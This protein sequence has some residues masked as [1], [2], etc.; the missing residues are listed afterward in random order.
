MSFQ[1]LGFGINSL[2]LHDSLNVSQD[3]HDDPMEIDEIH[4]NLDDQEVVDPSNNSSSSESLDISEDI[5]NDDSQAHSLL[6]ALSPTNLGAQ[7]ALKKQKLLMPPPPSASSPSSSPSKDSDL[8]DYEFDTSSMHPYRQLPFA[9]KDPDR[10]SFNPNVNSSFFSDVSDTPNTRN[11]AHSSF[12]YNTMMNRSYNY[13]KQMFPEQY[14]GANTSISVHEPDSRSSAVQVH[15]HHYYSSGYED[16]GS[17]LPGSAN[18]LK[19]YRSQIMPHGDTFDEKVTQVQ[20]QAYQGML[21]LPWD[22]KSSPAERVPYVLSSYLQLALNMVLS[23]YLLHIIVSIVQTI[24]QDVAHRLESQANNLLVEIASCERSYHENNCSPDTIVPALEKMCAYWEKCMNQ[25]PFKGGNTSSV[26]AQI[27]GMILN[28]LVEP[29]SFKVFLVA[30]GA[31]TV[32]FSC[33]FAFGYIRA[34]TYYGWAS[35]QTAGST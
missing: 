5:E 21:P 15:H 14:Q 9:S 34:K 35:A 6:N 8:H 25:D 1:E 12:Y 27:I 7:Y 33:N 20:R 23:C 10:S 22:S 31:I 32:V 11:D 4:F 13:R 16:S 24:R 19:Q 2:S 17:T 30:A 29:L 18:F 3:M 28:S 26:S